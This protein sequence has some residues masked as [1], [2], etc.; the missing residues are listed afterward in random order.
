PPLRCRRVSHVHCAAP[1]HF[2]TCRFRFP[3]RPPCPRPHHIWVFP[4]LP[5][6]AYGP[7][8]RLPYGRYLQPLCLVRSHHHCLIRVDDPWWPQSTDR[9]LSEVYG[10][11]FLS[12]HVFP[13]GHRH[14]VRYYRHTQ[15]GRLL[16]QGGGP[17]KPYP[18]RSHS[19]L[20]HR[21][22]RHQIAG[23]PALFLAALILP[24]PAP[25]R[26]CPPWRIAHPSGQLRDGPHVQP[27]VPTPRVPAYVAQSHCGLSRPFR[28]I[29]GRH[30]EQQPPHP[31]LPHRL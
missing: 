5:F 6:P 1:L 23:V 27:R 9:G 22:L 12:F 11:E 26:C 19:H 30:Q 15:H 28:H 20:L 4:H 3:R 16:A 31:R 24:Q 8:R 17:A 7:Q 29:R 2:R 21:R 13:H 14:P 18:R 25:C 10:H